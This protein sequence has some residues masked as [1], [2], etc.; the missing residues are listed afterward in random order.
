[1]PQGFLSLSHMPTA[2]FLPAAAG[3]M[4][5]FS[6]LAVM[7]NSL[8]LQFEGRGPFVQRSTPAAAAAPRQQ[9]QAQQQQKGGSWEPPKE[10]GEQPLAPAPIK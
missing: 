10:N 2:P 8:T 7:A 4:M 5:G 3:A 1:M 9:Q 6:S